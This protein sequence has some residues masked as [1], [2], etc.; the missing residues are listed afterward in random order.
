MKKT[1]KINTIFIENK[2][3]RSNIWSISTLHLYEQVQKG[4]KLYKNRN[5][6]TNQ[7]KDIAEGS[8]IL[9]VSKKCLFYLLSPA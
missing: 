1:T 2:Q 4:Y 5:S 7:F 9:H 3:K 8:E 6:L